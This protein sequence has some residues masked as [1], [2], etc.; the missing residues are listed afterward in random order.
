MKTP[1]LLA[2]CLALM[3]FACASVVRADE[4]V[5]PGES[6]QTPSASELAKLKQN[7]VSGLRQV[8][9]QTV[10]NPDIS[11]SGKTQAIY[12]IQPV[13]PIGINEDWKLITYSILPVIYQ[14]GLDGDDSSTGLGDTLI[15]LFF[16]PK[17]PGAV[18]WGVGPAIMLPTRT[19]S[20]L[21][22][23]R[24]GLGPTAVIF[25]AKDAWSAGLVLQNVWSLGGEGG[26]KVNTLG[27]QYIFNYNL[28]DG[29]FLLSNATISAN[30]LK[31]QRDRWT[32]PVGGG[33]GRVFNIGKQAVSLSAQT[34][35]NI[36]AT[37]SGS[38]IT[39][40]VQLTFMFP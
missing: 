11:D 30:W 31:D 19:D 37:S 35:Y 22:S 5:A 33:V 23:D 34:F 4:P 3:V 14:P 32:L 27:A 16:S 20:A 2:A 26:N 40:V 25:Y 15:N 28:A 13:F 6:K 7:P 10:V 17:K 18:V 36:D 29:W 12:S 38:D 21:G 24:L 8:I 1:Q 39:G 9:L